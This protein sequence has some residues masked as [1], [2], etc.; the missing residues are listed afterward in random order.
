M[1][2]DYAIGAMHGGRTPYDEAGALTGPARAVYAPT[3]VAVPTDA[4]DIV[5]RSANV[6][7][8]YPLKTGWL[9]FGLAADAPSY[10][11]GRESEG[12]EYQQPSGA[13]FQTITNIN[14]SMTLNVA[15]I[16]DKTLEII[17]NA[18]SAT[19]IAAEP[20]VGTAQKKINVGLY[21]STP[22]WRIALISFRPDG[23][24]E[25]EELA[26]SP[27]GTRPPMV[28]R[29]I[30]RTTITSDDTEMEFAR[31]EPVAAEVTFDAQSEPSAPSGGEHGFWIV[32]QEGTIAEAP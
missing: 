23:A 10:T 26:A 29:V 19:T 14:R 15:H 1:N 17:E 21:S 3:S 30:P 8:E 12:L 22:V 20:G 18:G 7:G 31:G 6:S 24:G 4:D 11:H 9:D 16:D 2:L 25:V 5:E 13:L 27:V 28:I 32:E